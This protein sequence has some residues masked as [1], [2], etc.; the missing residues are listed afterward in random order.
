[1]L[2]FIRLFHEDQ[3]QFPPLQ[4]TADRFGGNTQWAARRYKDLEDAG[5]IERNLVGKYRF[6]RE[7]EG[8]GA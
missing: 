3:D 4:Y 7:P 8:A 5:F 6:K 2:A 1:V